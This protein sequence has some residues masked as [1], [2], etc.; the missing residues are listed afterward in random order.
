MLVKVVDVRGKERF[1]NA[2]FIKSVIPRNDAQSDVEVS[3]W[4]SKVRVD[5]PADQVAAIVNAALPGNLDA[6]LAAEAE[7]QQQNQ[8]AII[9]V[10]G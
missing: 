2:A 8:A 1:V 4:A 9:A 10:I 6:L 3:G 5:Q 7:Q